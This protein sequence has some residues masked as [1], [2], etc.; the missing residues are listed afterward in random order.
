[1]IKRITATFYNHLPDDPEKRFRARLMLGVLTVLIGANTG[2]LIFFLFLAPAQM[3]AAA[4]HLA[5][6]STAIAGLINIF[7]LMLVLR[8]HL[9]IPALNCS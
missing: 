1:V 2:V 8:G 9:L 7:A 5:A 6:I 3:D 4:T